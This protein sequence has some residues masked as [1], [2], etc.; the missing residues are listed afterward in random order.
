MSDRKHLSQNRGMIAGRAVVAST[1]MR[2]GAPR[3]AASKKCTPGPPLPGYGRS[4]RPAIARP[5]ASCTE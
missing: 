4:A 2:I 1:A 5:S 3:Y